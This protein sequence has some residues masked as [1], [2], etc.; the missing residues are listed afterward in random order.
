[1]ESEV[2]AAFL[3]NVGQLVAFRLGAEDALLLQKEFA[4]KFGPGSLMQLDVGERIVKEGGR[5]AFISSP[6]GAG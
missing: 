6:T 1:M 2:R 3:G 5:D 4:G